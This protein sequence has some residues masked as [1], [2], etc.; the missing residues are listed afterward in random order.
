MRGPTTSTPRKSCFCFSSV[1]TM[2]AAYKLGS[3]PVPQVSF[4][5]EQTFGT[6]S[7]RPLVKGH[8]VLAPQRQV[9]RLAELSTEEFDDLFASVRAVQRSLCAS[10]ATIA[11]FNV[12]MKD[13]EGAGQP[14][15]HSHVHVV[16][17]RRGDLDRNDDIYD[18][19]DGWE[20]T[21]RPPQKVTL[22]VPSDDNRR[23]RT[24]DDMADEAAAYRR[25]R[26]GEGTLFKEDKKKRG[27]TTT[28]PSA[29]VTFGNVTL[30]HRQVFFA[31]ESSLAVV[32]LKPLVPGHVLV[33]PR[34]VAPTLCDL[35]DDEATDLWRTAR[36]VHHLVLGFHAKDSA[37]LAIQDGKDA[38]QSVPHVHVHVLPR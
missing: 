18:L 19:I 29:A 24:F 7:L 34:R 11:A 9:A 37:N 15:R 17:R 26:G 12:A 14:T 36:H 32:N 3:V 38:G 31:S 8:T 27:T 21:G 35:T 5:G 25:L 10:D 4:V 20:P 23:P 22:D 28:F 16:P 2:A 6:S 13:G 30:D 1:A 33:I